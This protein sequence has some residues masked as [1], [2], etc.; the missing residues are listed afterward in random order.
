MRQLVLRKA[1]TPSPPSVTAYEGIPPNVDTTLRSRQ[2]HRPSTRVGEDDICGASKSAFDLRKQVVGIAVLGHVC[3]DHQELRGSCIQRLEGFDSLVQLVLSATSEN[4]TSGASS[5]PNS[6]D[7]LGMLLAP[8]WLQNQR[9]R[10]IY[11]ANAGAASGNN[12]YLVL[13][14]SPVLVILR[15]KLVLYLT[16]DRLRQLEWQCVLQRGVAA[17]CRHACGQM[18]HE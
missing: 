10:K 1:P 18:I 4:D 12:D 11:C 7:G 8:L 13:G 17:V 15:L 9:A 16:M 2:L 5:R 14:R 3:R 6:C